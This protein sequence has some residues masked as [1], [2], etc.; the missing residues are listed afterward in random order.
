MLSVT[1]QTAESIYTLLG[2][3][4][5]ENEREALENPTSKFFFSRLPDFARKMKRLV[6]GALSLGSVP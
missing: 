5:M 4:M 2:I 6:E 1:G 3:M